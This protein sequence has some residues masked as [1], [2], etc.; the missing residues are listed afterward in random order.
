VLT[1][2]PVANT[3]LLVGAEFKNDN[4]KYYDTV[5]GADGLAYG[6]PHFGDTVIKVIS[7]FR[8]MYTL[9]HYTTF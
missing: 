9:N 5:C 2:S 3:T 8:L 6:I 4:L 7:S 1:H